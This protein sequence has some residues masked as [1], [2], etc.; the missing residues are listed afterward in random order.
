MVKGGRAVAKKIPLAKIGELL[1]ICG[2]VVALVVGAAVGVRPVSAAAS[3]GIVLFLAIL[4]VIVGL[5][6]VTEEEAG[7]YML[8]AVALMVAATFGANYSTINLIGGTLSS[9]GSAISS[10]L[11]HVGAFVA[12]AAVLISIKAVYKLAHTR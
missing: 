9:L 3:G 4:G 11:V 1:F 6:T 7:P 10:L 5:T 2:F 12:P 8:A